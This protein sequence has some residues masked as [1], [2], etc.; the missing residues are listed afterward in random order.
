M[1]DI[2][3]N[4]GRN[5][6]TGKSIYELREAVSNL[7]ISHANSR[8]TWSNS[9]NLTNDVGDS[10]NNSCNQK[11][12]C[13]KGSYLTTKRVS[14]SYDDRSNRLKGS[15]WRSGYRNGDR[16]DL[17]WYDDM[18]KGTVLIGGH[19]RHSTTLEVG[20]ANRKVLDVNRI[21]WHTR[22]GAVK[23]GE[24]RRRRPRMIDVSISELVFCELLF[25]FFDSV[26]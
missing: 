7:N 6:L 5:C 16:G 4:L 11:D 22:V 13:K 2:W 25:K 3:L 20:N 21:F 18:I 23:A 9:T 26:W 24:A 10:R 8:H 12:N 1:H 17:R 14:W 19:E 15:Q